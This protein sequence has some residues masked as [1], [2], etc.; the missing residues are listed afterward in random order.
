MRYE[1]V[2]IPSFDP[3]RRLWSYHTICS[4]WSSLLDGCPSRGKSA[5]NPDIF[6]LCRLLYCTFSHSI[7]WSV[8]SAR[9]RHE[10][11]RASHGNAEPYIMR[12][13]ASRQ[14]VCLQGRRVYPGEPCVYWG[15]MRM[16]G[17]MRILGGMRTPGT[18]VYTGR[19]CGCR[20][21]EGGAP[22]TTVA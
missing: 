2:S 18:H 3:S 9:M 7:M 19:E 5:V 10:T 15:A 17:A 1:C 20:G 16:L 6:A 22:V 12:D 14:G 11:S 8:E 13:A 4:T 21:G